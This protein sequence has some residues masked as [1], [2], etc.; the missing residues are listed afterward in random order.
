[1]IFYRMCVFKLISALEIKSICLKLFFINMT[2]LF[3][4]IKTPTIIKDYMSMQST[5][6][7][8]KNRFF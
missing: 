3:S 6:H 5:I 7:K 4:Q 1:M 2:K 8:L